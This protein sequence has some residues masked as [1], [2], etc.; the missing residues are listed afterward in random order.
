ML[1]TTPGD[2]IISLMRSASDDVLIAA[3]YIKSNTLCRIIEVLPDKVSQFRCVTRWLPEDIASGACDIKI[4]DDVLDK[5]GGT[6]L[7]HPYLHAKY[8][9]TA[10]RCLVGSAN[11]TSRGLGWAIRS[12]IELLVELPTES[13]G[14]SQWENNLL[15]SSI[16]ATI[17]L[18]DQLLKQVELLNQNSEIPNVP[19]VENLEETSTNPWTPN[20]PAPGRLWEV[21]R[22][23]GTD[24]MVSSAREAARKDLET[25]APPHGLSED[26]FNA[27]IAGILKQM[28]LMV[29][30]DQLANT[31]LY[32][33]RA[34]PW[35]SEKLYSNTGHT[36]DEAE[37]SPEV[38]QKWLTIKNWLIHFFPELY[39]LEPK[40]EVLVRG[41]TL[42]QR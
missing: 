25:L 17:E 37:Y 9:R 5:M 11:L 3:P 29:E 8:Y 42:P 35:I 22:G 39:R 10:N 4:Y 27:Y 34:Y 28:P 1:A 33:A 38:R 15:T 14:I 18:R 12:N 13:P 7:I 23:N 21:Y 19:E 24:N 20:C 2:S 26:L 16:P 41:R 40:Q 31:G 36:D 32:E 30:I 6:L